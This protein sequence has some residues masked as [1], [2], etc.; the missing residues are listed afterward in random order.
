MR[1]AWS[2]EGTSGFLSG[3]SGKGATDWSPAWEKRPE[4]R[5]RLHQS[6]AIKTAKA[7]AKAKGYSYTQK[8]DPETNEVVLLLRNVLMKDYAEKSAVD[9]KERKTTSRGQW[10]GFSNSLPKTGHRRNQRQ[11]LGYNTVG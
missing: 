5:H 8:V 6:L 2:S 9:T 7:F 4:I 1:S 10:I 3:I 11:N